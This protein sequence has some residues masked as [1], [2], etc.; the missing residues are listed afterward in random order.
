M[1]FC[2]C[3][4]SNGE[5]SPP[6]HTV[7]RTDCPR[8]GG[9]LPP[10]PFAGG[11]GLRHGK[12][13]GSSS[14]LWQIC[15]SLHASLFFFFNPS[16]PRILYWMSPLACRGGPHPGGPPSCQGNGDTRCTGDHCSF[17]LCQRHSLEP[18]GED[19]L[20]AQASAL[21]A[22]SLPGAGGQAGFLERWDLG[23]LGGGISQ[24]AQEQKPPAAS[25]GLPA[26]RRTPP[27][28]VPRRR[29]AQRPPLLFV[30]LFQW[31]SC[32]WVF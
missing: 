17:P 13:K 12:I 31:I 7:G 2:L 3:R 8:R 25:K 28:R 5:Q 22:P 26:P 1:I 23:K 14:Q 18:S 6:C 10:S 15:I 19:E 27:E 11:G 20:R 32:S 9:K 29:R 16:P 30:H 4:S 21:P 24:P